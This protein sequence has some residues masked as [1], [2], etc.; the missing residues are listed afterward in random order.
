MYG[1]DGF[2]A[3]GFAGGGDQFGNDQF[4][5]GGG[6][7]HFGGQQ[8]QASQP[9]GGGGGFHQVDNA[10]PDGK[11][12]KDRQSLLPVTIKQLKNAQSSVG[13]QT[14]TVDGQ[15]V[16][17]VTIVGV[18]MRAEEANTNLQ[19]TI[20]DGTGDIDVKKWIDAE[21]DGAMV[22]QRAMCREG[23]IVRVVGQLRIFNHT[24]SVVAFNI[25]PIVDFNEYTFHFIECVH[26]H[27]RHTRGNPPAGGAAVKG[28]MPSVAA[29]GYQ[30]GMQ[31]QR[32]AA[33]VNISDTVLQYFRNY[34]NSDLGC[35][36][37][38][39]FEAMKASGTTMPQLRE[40]IDNLIN[41]GHL[42]STVDDDHLKST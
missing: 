2:D 22:E 40:S 39:C 1:A 14:F 23:K 5:M 10:G 25:Q 13:D 33:Q 9:A 38:D 15:D 27:L 11:T 41:D 29:G 42:Y 35:T 20:D 19:Y 21:A 8:F 16:H 36:V 7:D 3:G 26:T 17:Q 4:M 6:G 28:G 18:I 34:S 12:K 31:Q 30:A 32:P 24:R 37:H